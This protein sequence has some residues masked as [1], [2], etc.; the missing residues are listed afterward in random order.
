[1]K[2]ISLAN[3]SYEDAIVGLMLHK[4]A[5]D[6]GESKPLP[7]ELSDASLFVKAAENFLDKIKGFAS[8]VQS[9]A[10]DL[11]GKAYVGL[12]ENAPKTMKA[13]QD[14]VGGAVS[15]L[16]A[17]AAASPS[18]M[19]QAKSWANKTKDQ[20]NDSFKGNEGYRDALLYGLAGT[21]IGA[22]ASLAHSVGTGDKNWKR[23]ALR[24][25][26][27]G[28][29]AGVGVNLLMNA[30]EITNKVSDQLASPAAKATKDM[31]SEQ[32]T[33]HVS[34]ANSY[35]PEVGAAG[36]ASTSIPFVRSLMSQR[37]RESFDPSM[38]RTRLQGLVTQVA[39][40]K[41]PVKALAGKLNP[42]GGI[43]QLNMLL[44][45]TADQA[46]D[47]NGLARL[48]K[49]IPNAAKSAP[50]PSALEQHLAAG[51]T[52][53]PF[54]LNPSL[55]NSSSIPQSSYRAVD[56]KAIDDMLGNS[57]TLKNLISQND[58][59]ESAPSWFKPNPSP[60][61][62]QRIAKGILPTDQADDFARGLTSKGFFQQG[63]DGWKIKPKHAKGIGL[64]GGAATAI[65]GFALENYRRNI[66]ERAKSQEALDGLDYVHAA[67]GGILE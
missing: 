14:T 22:G 55:A 34:R 2:A 29:G 19:D 58:V 25:A 41:D 50:I 6:K 53:Q 42:N 35:A 61:V 60:T 12:K 63:A 28:G 40:D 49:S 7:K 4:E 45:D 43:Q 46:T 10:T 33:D 30:D 36:I 59:A 20:F 11:A 66:A 38:L 27:I 24:N 57:Q 37:N 15:K 56:G 48:F 67:T 26:L 3:I 47:P 16:P 21:G 51:A 18:W 65:L 17:P 13:V 8:S 44:G 9:D 39:N 5:L 32:L 54:G 1:M 64:K 52:G 31:S 62:S 23:K